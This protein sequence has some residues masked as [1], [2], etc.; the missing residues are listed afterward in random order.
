MSACLC[1]GVGPGEVHAPDEAGGEAAAGGGLR[2]GGRRPEEGPAA[3]GRPLLR[4][5]GVRTPPTARRAQHTGAAPCQRTLA[6]V[7]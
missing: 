7:M 6:S 5:R 4:H 2:G 1:T 3:A